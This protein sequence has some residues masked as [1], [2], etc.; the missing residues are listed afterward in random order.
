MHLVAYVSICSLSQSNRT[1]L[2]L[3]SIKQAPS[4]SPLIGGKVSKIRK[5]QTS[6]VFPTFRGTAMPSSS[7]SSDWRKICYFKTSV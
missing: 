3:R 1:Y 6:G 2:Q 7:A 5:I 4:S